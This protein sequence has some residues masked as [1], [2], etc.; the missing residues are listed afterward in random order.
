[1]RAAIAFAVMFALAGCGGS[2]DELPGAVAALERKLEA[3]SGVL[4]VVTDELRV[5]HEAGRPDLPPAG[6]S[7]EVWLDLGGAGWR[8]HRTTRDGG[9][10]QVAD[11]R[12]IRTVTRGGFVDLDR[13]D[14]ED[15]D[16]L[17]R[18][19]RAAAVVDPVR[20]VREGGLRAV[21]EATV[22]GRDAHVVAVEPDPSSRTRLYVA[23]EGGELLRITHRRERA[24]A[25]RTIIQDY[26]RF[27]VAQR[28]PRTLAEFLGR[29]TR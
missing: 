18:P 17:L 28:R 26:L 9:F 8:A 24:G 13:A 22:H 25:A 4:H 19:W 11:E 21:G 16:F 2:G 27:E 15:P 1:M 5:A 20:L 29:A 7:D 6:W 14:G 12:G 23:V 3:P 10:Q